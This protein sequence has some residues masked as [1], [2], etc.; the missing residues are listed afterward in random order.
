MLTLEQEFEQYKAQHMYVIVRAKLL[1][2]YKELEADKTNVPDFMRIGQRA[3]DLA[4]RDMN[5]LLTTK[6]NGEKYKTLYEK[7]YQDLAEVLD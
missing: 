3:E 4:D 1:T 5:A 7:A 2:Y 6:D